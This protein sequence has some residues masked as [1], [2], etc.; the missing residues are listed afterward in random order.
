MYVIK[1]WKFIVKMVENI[2]E[3]GENA[4]YQHLF[5]FPPFF[6]FRVFFR[7]VKILDCLLQ[8]LHHFQQY[9]GQT[10]ALIFF[11]EEQCLKIGSLQD[12]FGFVRISQNFLLLLFSKGEII[13]QPMTVW[14]CKLHMQNCI[15]PVTLCVTL[16]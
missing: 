9:F 1:K 2:V 5:L 7:V 6:F 15:L 10:A 13:Q 16:S 14:Y 8:G 12:L 11:Q 4:G 3:K